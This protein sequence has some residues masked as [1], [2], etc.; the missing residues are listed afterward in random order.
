MDAS[1]ETA[2]KLRIADIPKHALITLIRAYK[3]VVSPL[4]PSACRYV[5][6]CSEYAIEAIDRHGMVLGAMMA[7]W[8]L[9]RCHPWARGG[10]DPVRLAGVPTSPQISRAAASREGQLLV[11]S[12]RKRS[13]KMRHPG[14][15]KQINRSLDHPLRHA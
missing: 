3:Y 5:P 9:L 12:D 11:F 8:R 4:L 6:T 15:T 14:G 10:F 7:G 2:L 13:R 1:E